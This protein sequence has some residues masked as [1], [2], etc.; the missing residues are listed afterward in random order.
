MGHHKPD[1]RTLARVVVEQVREM[2][3]T[4]TEADDPSVAELVLQCWELGIVAADVMN[5]R[6]SESA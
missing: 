2:G 4:F 6:E 1:A 3:C 5:Q